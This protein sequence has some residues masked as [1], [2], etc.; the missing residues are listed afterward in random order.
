MTPGRITA[1][2]FLLSALFA[3]A[4][5]T[6]VPASDFAWVDLRT[7]APAIRIE[8]RYAT[9]K[10][11]AHRPLYPSGMQPMVRAGV[12]R[13]LIAAQSILRRFH[14]GLKIW[15]VYRPP[16]T[17]A[18]LWRLA[19][20]N[21]YVVNPENGSGSFHAWGGAVD[22]TIVDDCGRPLSMPTD[23]DDFTPAAMFRYTGTDPLLRTHLY[24][25]Q[26]TM[27]SAGFSGLRTEWWHFTTSDW[28]RYV[29]EH[30][31]RLADVTLPN[32]K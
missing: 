5:T 12:D 25:L 2:V 32:N 11:I 17:Q 18:E 24:V 7:I 9:F 20:R 19:P 6:A 29:P 31:A 16:D 23:F 14:C 27:L 1:A 10:N 30:L 8:L 15:D 4:E 28:N 22:A 3:R 13:R 21:D 26:R